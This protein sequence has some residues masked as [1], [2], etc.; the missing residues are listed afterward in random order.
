M[1]DIDDHLLSLKQAVGEE[2]S[3]SQCNSSVSL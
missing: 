2:L 1:N 3:G